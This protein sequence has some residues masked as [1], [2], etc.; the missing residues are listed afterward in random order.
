MGP[1]QLNHP[2]EHNVA[3]EA[4]QTVSPRRLGERIFG[5]RNYE[6]RLK[7]PRESFRGRASMGKL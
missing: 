2:R 3:T 5:E 1:T 6:E 7:V 4:R